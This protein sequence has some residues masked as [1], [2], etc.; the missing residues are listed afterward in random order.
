MRGD[1]VVQFKDEN[2]EATSENDR[3]EQR[4]RKGEK[5]SL[6][7]EL[8]TKRHCDTSMIKHASSINLSVHRPYLLCSTSFCSCYHTV[9]PVTH[10]GGRT[11]TRNFHCHG[12]LI[13][14]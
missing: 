12:K 4:R 9:T 5:R 2:R 10:G 11:M 13:I 8:P 6:K 3:G 14:C 7:K 1:N